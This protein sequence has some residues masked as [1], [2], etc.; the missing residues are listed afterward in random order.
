MPCLGQC[1]SMRT[2]FKR[3]IACQYD[4]NDLLKACSGTNSSLDKPLLES[5]PPAPN[6]YILSHDN[7]KAIQAPKI[8]GLLYKFYIVLGDS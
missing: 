7:P 4:D 5:C 8:I 6:Y 2:Y 1:L 3:I